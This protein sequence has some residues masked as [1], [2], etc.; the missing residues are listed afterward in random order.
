M[1]D[2]LGPEARMVR[3]LYGVDAAKATL[4]ARRQMLCRLPVEVV[5]L[6]AHDDEEVRR[7]GAEIGLSILTGTDEQVAFLEAM[8]TKASHKLREDARWIARAG[9]LPNW[10]K[11]ISWD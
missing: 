9:S 11:D 5:R 8:T 10:R 2:E 7:Q 6:L 4:I 1:N 3:R